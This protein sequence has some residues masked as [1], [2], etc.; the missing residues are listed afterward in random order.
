LYNFSDQ[1]SKIRSPVPAVASRSRRPQEAEAEVALLGRCRG[2]GRGRRANEAEI[3][4]CLS[5]PAI[6][7]S[8]RETQ[9]PPTLQ[10]QAD[11]DADADAEA[12]TDADAD[13]GSE[14]VA[15]RRGSGSL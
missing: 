6:T 5:K 3:A 4:A 2:S 13:A 1:L 8:R 12:Q 11:A 7:S 15:D 10:R 14:V 9:R